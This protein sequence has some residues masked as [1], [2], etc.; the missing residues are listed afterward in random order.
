MITFC[1]TL[2]GTSEP[3]AD[4]NTLLGKA[5]SLAKEVN[6]GVFWVDVAYPA[7]IGPAN[8]HQNLFGDSL[9]QSIDQGGKA[10]EAS[11][12]WCRNY[13]TTRDESDYRIVLL[14]YSLGALVVQEYLKHQP[15][16]GID[17]VIL[18][19][20]PG[21][22]YLAP[23]MGGWR[24][25]GSTVYSGIA[26]GMMNDEKLGTD[27]NRLDV[28]HVA[29][30]MDPIANLHPKS[31][32]RSICPW[33]WAMDLDNP[34]P[35]LNTIME[36]IQKTQMWAW[37]RFWEPGYRDAVNEMLPD[38]QRYL[39]KYH[40]HIYEEPEWTTLFG[41]KM[42]GIEVIAQ[43]INDSCWLDKPNRGIQL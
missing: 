26:S 30:R 42:T 36:E 19:S 3:Y 21:G 2:R 4:G 35:W 34:I 41:K 24:R 23:W 29:H 38:L 27:M 25:E 15:S 43:R 33:L 1:L 37:L 39:T 28:W 8:E 32:L 6:D 9:A 40:T 18:L 7:S 16:A 12:E 31:P 22:K 17:R 13:A 11:I 14:G 10:I 5:V 20:N